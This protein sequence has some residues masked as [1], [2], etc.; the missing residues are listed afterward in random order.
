VAGAEKQSIAEEI[1]EAE[2]RL[3]AAE[4]RLKAGR[5][6]RA[7]ADHALRAEVRQLRDE[8]DAAR[9][10]VAREVGA[11][12]QRL[13]RADTDVAA[14]TAAVD[15]LH[16]AS[17]TERERLS[18]ELGRLADGLSAVD[19][20]R[21]DVGRDLGR[22]T[23]E[24][25]QRAAAIDDANAA[26]DELRIQND[27]TDELFAAL[28]TLRAEQA[29][30]RAEADER[31]LRTDAA[32]GRVA[33]LEAAAEAFSGR[34]HGLEAGAEAAAVEMRR[35]RETSDRHEEAER[36]RAL[37]R[38]V[39]ALGA[40]PPSVDAAGLTEAQ[41]TLAALTPSGRARVAAGL[42]GEAAR[43]PPRPWLPAALRTL[44]V[45][46]PA[47]A[48]RLVLA[49]LPASAVVGAPA[50]PWELIVDGHG[51]WSVVPGEVLADVNRDGELAAPRFRV[52]GDVPA[53]AELLDGRRAS[54][55]R[56]Q[57]RLDLRGRRA[58]GRKH[59]AAIG[60]AT[61]SPADLARTGVWLDPALLARALALRVDP[62]AVGEERFT[63]AVSLAGPV[64]ATFAVTAESGLAVTAGAPASG[65]DATL[66]TTTLAFY[67]WLSGEPIDAPVAIDGDRDAVARLVAWA[68]RAAERR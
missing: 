58:A 2:R 49:L 38:R 64:G 39:E 57:G 33:A 15:E 13:E 19:D 50:P 35:L 17:R 8:F 59:L 18:A 67:R 10:Q 12:Y 28:A 63:V 46:D 60:R 31:E 65:P 42:R 20:W 43:W 36:L 26:I 66:A 5:E 11:L 29:E 53:L 25:A 45:E 23:A 3:S 62:A 55:A 41:A 61:R 48:M 4:R 54:R 6:A 7:D 24:L 16:E 56:L 22:L 1:E 68:E 14:A 40:P 21:G 37:E 27:R 30:L 9:E 44:A 51:R 34:L 32:E 52:R 47:A